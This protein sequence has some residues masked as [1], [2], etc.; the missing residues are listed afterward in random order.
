VTRL[1]RISSVENVCRHF[2]RISRTDVPPLAKKIDVGAGHYSQLIL[3][4][5]QR[6]KN[7]VYMAR[8]QKKEALLLPI[9]KKPY[10]P[11]LRMGISRREGLNVAP[12]PAHNPPIYL[13][14][15]SDCNPRTRCEWS[16]QR[17]RVD[18][19]RQ[20][21]PRIRERKPPGGLARTDSAAGFACDHG[22][23]ILLGLPP[24]LGCIFNEIE[25]SEHPGVSGI[26]L[27]AHLDSVIPAPLQLN[28][29]RLPIRS[30]A[31]LFAGLLRDRLWPGK[32]RK[33][34]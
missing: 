5:I 18:A 32:A 7:A 22:P 2:G 10:S 11:Q 31:L 33:L 1:T 21:I 25:L 29:N 20:S 3:V 12:I 17:D 16:W 28:L 6:L 15:A 26:A 4:K 19:S 9:G 30:R 24:E 34:H 23:H 14:H 13:R 8:R 27:D